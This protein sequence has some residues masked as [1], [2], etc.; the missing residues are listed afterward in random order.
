[1]E[2][3]G[4]QRESDRQGP[5]LQEEEGEEEGGDQGV[6]GEE[7]EEVGEEELPGCGSPR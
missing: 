5:S 4:E 7:E 2:K 1:M 3:D 6:V